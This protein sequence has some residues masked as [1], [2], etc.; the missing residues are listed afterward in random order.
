[1]ESIT[2]IFLEKLIEAWTHEGGRE[3]G[4]DKGVGWDDC[5]LT[6]K[7]SR[8]GDHEPPAPPVIRNRRARAQRG[9]PSSLLSLPPPPP[10]FFTFDSTLRKM[11]YPFCGLSYFFVEMP[12]FSSTVVEKR[13]R[14]LTKKLRRF[15]SVNSLFHSLFFFFLLIVAEIVSAL[16]ACPT[17]FR[18]RFQ[19]IP[20]VLAHF[21]P[22]R[23]HHTPV[24]RNRV[25]FSPLVCAEPAAKGATPSEH[26]C[27]PTSHRTALRSPPFGKF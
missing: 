18:S 24:A 7:F 11:E 25:L 13:S 17:Q 1:M 26:S 3:G 19:S 12:N 5:I 15:L 20:R 22:P 10:F 9:C 4:G 23:S 21:T 2:C 27:A 6:R 16:D 14:R 8:L